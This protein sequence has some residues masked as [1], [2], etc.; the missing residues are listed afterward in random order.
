MYPDY[1]FSFFSTP[2][3]SISFS[4][5][6]ILH[7]RSP[8]E[9]ESKSREKMQSSVQA[10]NVDSSAEETHSCLG[11]VLA[12]IG[13]PPASLATIL[14]KSRGKY[15]GKS[16]RRSSLK[17]RQRFSYA[18]LIDIRCA[19]EQDPHIEITSESKPIH[20]QSL[21][22]DSLSFSRDFYLTRVD[23]DATAGYKTH[24]SLYSFSHSSPSSF[25][26]SKLSSNSRSSSPQ[27]VNTPASSLPPSS[28]SKTSPASFPAQSL[29][30]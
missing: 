9:L 6:N 5:I 2:Y 26:L 29:S 30:S 24:F 22:L 20:F 14:E 25:S 15:E 7:R 1:S 11:A 16:G 23:C 13:A 3:T 19:L 18:M 17:S 8:V 12:L 4:S 21:C 27:C 10:R 28:L